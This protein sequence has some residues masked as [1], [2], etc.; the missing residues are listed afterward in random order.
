MSGDMISSSQKTLGYN[1]YST[2]ERGQSTTVKIW[3]NH[4]FTLRKEAVPAASS[5]EG[6]ALSPLD[7]RMIYLT[8]GFMIRCQSVKVTTPSGQFLMLSSSW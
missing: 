8:L 2:E 1:R 6:K 5:G 4:S 3:Q 7:I